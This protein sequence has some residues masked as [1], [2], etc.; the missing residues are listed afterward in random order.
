M[1][2]AVHLAPPYAL[3]IGDRPH[4]VEDPEPNTLG[5]FFTEWGVALTDSCVG[6]F[7][8]PK[9]IAFYVDG[10]PYTGDPAAIELTDQKEIAIVIGTPPAEIPKTADF[11]KE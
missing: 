9:P 3:R 5:Q 8:S 2:H 10:E 1:R 4:G 6:E 11:S 7:C